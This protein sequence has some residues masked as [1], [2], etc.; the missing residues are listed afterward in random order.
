M[1]PD[2][3]EKARADGTRDAV[4]SLSLAKTA[5]TEHAK[6][7][8]VALQNLDRLKGSKG[9]NF[10]VCPTCGFTVE[11]VDFAMCPSCFTPR[12]E[13]EQIA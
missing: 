3:L 5:E 4:R 11:E 1:Y 8:A 7:Y 13:F 10:L 9:K 6:L 2:F 12:D